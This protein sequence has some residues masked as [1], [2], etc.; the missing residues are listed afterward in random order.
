MPTANTAIFE[1]GSE[2]SYFVGT[3]GRTWE[4]GTYGCVRSDGWRLHEG[5]DIAAI[6]RDKRGEALDP[7]LATADGKVVYMNSHS[8]LSNY[9]R[10]LILEH[11]IDRLKI[12][13]LYAHLSSFVDGLAV[14]SVVRKSDR[15]ATMGR[16]TN[17]SEGISR[18]R[19]HLHFEINLLLNRE[20]EGW[21]DKHLIGATND[22]GMWNGLNLV[23][24]DA[25]EIF[26]Q[27][28]ELGD[29][30]DLLR[31][32]REQKEFCRVR[33]PSADFAW[34]RDHPQL[35]RWNDVAM[36]EGIV[37]YELVL[38]FNGMPFQ[39]IPRARSEFNGSNRI[40]LLSV[41]EDHYR[42]HRCCRLVTQS[43]SWKLASRGMRWIERLTYSSRG[44]P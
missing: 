26:R 2:A 21:F 9:G 20:F 8:G 17:T 34:L 6:Q 27:Q 29:R 43:G 3:V 25:W 42:D 18:E 4:S 28:R 24:L 19:A 13:S 31:Y 15:I 44:R 39:A 16:T 37:A 38:S 33:V 10:Y 14:G 7:V 32:I 23:G 30:F 12:Y 11:E 40:E 35:I 5:I 36:R 1:Q 41:N 22:H